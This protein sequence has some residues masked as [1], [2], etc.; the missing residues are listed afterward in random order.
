MCSSWQY[1]S[2]FFF[3]FKYWPVIVLR[4]VVKAVCC[5]L[6]LSKS[7]A[8]Y[9]WTLFCSI[10]LFCIYVII[11]HFKNYYSLAG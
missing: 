1:R 9:V 6:Q 10:D 7:V 11:P 3:F 8:L 5:L 2:K 4:S